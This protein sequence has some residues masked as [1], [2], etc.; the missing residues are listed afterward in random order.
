M[1]DARK[2]FRLFKTLNEYKKIDDI[3]K[4]NPQMN[5]NNILAI[6]TR[7]FFGVYWIYDNLNILSK[8]KIINKDPKAYAKTGSLFWLFALLINLIT[9]IK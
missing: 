3:I 1:R 8:I 5:V 2:L 6:L 4:K 7:A 9:V